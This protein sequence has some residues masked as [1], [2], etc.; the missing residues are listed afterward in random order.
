MALTTG[1]TTMLQE[2]MA[3]LEEAFD[4][5]FEECDFTEVHQ[6]VQDIANF[7]NKQIR[8]GLV[9]GRVIS[10]QEIKG[11]GLSIEALIITENRKGLQ[12]FRSL[13]IRALQKKGFPR[14]ILP[15]K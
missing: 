4:Y 15:T 13:C 3:I 8:E 2:K 5:L 6:T 14:E 12:T 7:L 10:N 9:K 1:S 11:C